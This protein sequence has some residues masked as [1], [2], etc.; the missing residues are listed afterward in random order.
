MHYKP[1]ESLGSIILLLFGNKRLHFHFSEGYAFMNIRRYKPETLRSIRQCLS[2][3]SLHNLMKYYSQTSSKIWRYL[4]ISEKYIKHLTDILKS[5]LL[6][7]LVFNSEANKRFRLDTWFQ[8][9]FYFAVSRLRIWITILYHFIEH[10]CFIFYMESL[11]H[12]ILETKIWYT[13]YLSLLEITSIFFIEIITFFW[14]KLS[15]LETP[16]FFS[17]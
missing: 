3:I 13:G 8:L 11:L 7:L 17:I 10:N 12:I 9:H 15:L 1:L 4:K 6:F 2:N 14:R 16:R 5:T